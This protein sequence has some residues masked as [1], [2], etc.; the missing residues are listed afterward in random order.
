MVKIFDIVGNM[1]YVSTEESNQYEID[2][3]RFNNGLYFVNIEMTNG[4]INTFK[5]LK[6]D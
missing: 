1:K 5:V 4:Q 6:K 3:S 2:F